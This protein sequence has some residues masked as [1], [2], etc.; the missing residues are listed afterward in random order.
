MQADRVR[1]HASEVGRRLLFADDPDPRVLQ[2]V[3]IALVGLDFLLRSVDGTPIPLALLAGARLRAGGRA[4]RRHV[5]RSRGTACRASRSA[6]SRCSTS[7]PSAW[8]RLDDRGQRRRGRDRRTRPVAR[9][10]VRQ[11]RRRDDLRR[12]PGADRPALGALPRR[13]RGQPVPLADGAARRGVGRAG[14]RQRPRED[15]RRVR[16]RRR[17]AGRA[18]AGDAHHRRAAPLRRGDPRHRRRGPGPAGPHRCLPHPEPAARRLHAAGLPRRARRPGRPARPRVRPRRRHR[19]DPRRDADVPRLPG[20]GVRRLPDLGRR[21]PAVAA[22]PVGV[23]ALRTRQGR[24]ASPAP[25]WRTRTSP[26]SCGRS[27]SRTS[28]SPRSPTSCA[29]RSPRSWGTSTSCSSAP[30]STPSRPPTSHVVSRN[31]DRLRRLVADLLHSAQIDEGPMNVVRTEADLSAIVHQSLLTAAPVAKAGG[32]LPGLGRTRLAA[33]GRGRA[34]DV[35]GRRQPAVERGQVHPRGRPGAGGA[36]RRRRP[37]RAGRQRHRHRHLR[38]RPERLFTR[39]FRAGPAEESSI[40]GIGLGLSITKSIVES[41]GGRIEVE[42]EPGRGSTFRV[43]L[44]LDAAHGCRVAPGQ[45]G[46][47]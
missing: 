29:R 32:S 15:Q 1:M 10:P 42:S 5:R 19:A 8:L 36:A 13:R 20:R 46:A 33:G 41:H 47:P 16:R 30:T 22:G 7:W 14:R 35:A 34:A 4:D 17:E 12:R 18:G 21:R 9:P 43:R 38:S 2:G 11:A 25:R 6:S 39:F 23:G 45:L 24:H 44:P 40:Q 3:F 37:G 31:S 26:T 27:G 28:S